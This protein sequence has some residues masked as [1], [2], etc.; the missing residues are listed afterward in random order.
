[1]QNLCMERMKKIMNKL[2]SL[3]S[4]LLFFSH[5]A[6]AE[7]A[8]F[9]IKAGSWSFAT[10]NVSVVSESSSGFGAYS[11]EFAYGFYPKFLMVGAF[12]L[13]MSEVVT[14]SSGFGFDFGTRYFPLTDATRVTSATDSLEISIQEKY[15]PYIGLFFR[16]RLFNL[17]LSTSYIGPGISFGIDYSPWKKWFASAEIRYDQ[18]YGPG[19]AIA[20]QLNILFGIGFE[21]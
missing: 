16:Q 15:R 12:N 9:A 19:D 3:I 11:F 20:N 6:F 4:F 14:G 21:I 13:L 8:S 2:L 10:E 1:M 7:K 18:L 17:A 5:S